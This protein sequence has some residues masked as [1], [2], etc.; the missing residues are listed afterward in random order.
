[1]R[2]KWLWACVT[3]TSP[4]AD[5][6]SVSV[7]N[8]NDVD[9]RTTETEVFV[10]SAQKNLIEERM[11]LCA[12]LWDNDIKVND[13]CPNRW[14]QGTL[15][16]GEGSVRNTSLHELVVMSSFFNWKYYLPFYKTSYSN[17]D[18]NCTVYFPSVKVPLAQCYKTFYVCNSQMFGI[19]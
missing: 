16:V 6:W 13:S 1:M 18:V 7:T 4:T 9:N 12:Q 8:K 5:I 2:T 17:E 15:S 14:P 10:A 19:S 3:R 11:K